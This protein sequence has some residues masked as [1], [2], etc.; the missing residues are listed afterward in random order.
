MS[1]HVTGIVT[2]ASMARGATYAARCSCGWVGTT[3]EATPAAA[4]REAA[5]HQDHEAFEAWRSRHGAG[6]TLQSPPPGGHPQPGDT[7]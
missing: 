7:A 4:T 1:D 2:W 5:I 6:G 3:R